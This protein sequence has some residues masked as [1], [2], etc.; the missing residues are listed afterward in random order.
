[1]S[2]VSYFTSGRLC[3]NPL[4]VRTSASV[5]L[6][7]DDDWCRKWFGKETNLGSEE[8]RDTNFG[9]RVLVTAPRP[10]SGWGVGP[11]ECPLPFDVR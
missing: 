4:S 6:V 5:C 7:V 9:T 11:F 3:R 8:I 1:M 10:A 2:R